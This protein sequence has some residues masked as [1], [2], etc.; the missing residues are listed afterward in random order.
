MTVWSL[1]WY[2][3]FAK[4]LKLLIQISDTDLINSWS[5]HRGSLILTH[6]DLPALNCEKARRMP[7]GHRVASTNPFIHTSCHWSCTKDHICPL[8]LILLHQTTLA[9]AVVKCPSSIHPSSRVRNIHSY[10][11][12]WIPFLPD[13]KTSQD[14]GSKGCIPNGVTYHHCGTI[15]V[16]VKYMQKLLLLE[17]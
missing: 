2:T 3:V 4:M 11:T 12:G 9:N 8:W 1:L 7:N 14:D 17:I 6:C 13:H 5:C 10:T 16:R 15:H